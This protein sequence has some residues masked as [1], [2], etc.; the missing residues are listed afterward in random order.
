MNHQRVQVCLGARLGH[1][2]ETAA[3]VR[4]QQMNVP[5]N[6]RMNRCAGDGVGAGNQNVRAEEF[7]DR[8]NLIFR[9]GIC[10]ISHAEVLLHLVRATGR[11]ESQLADIELRP[12][13]IRQNISQRIRIFAT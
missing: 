1:G 6:S 9:L 12:Q 8:R 5:L 7:P 4:I 11:D 13:T 10:R 3:I 2:A